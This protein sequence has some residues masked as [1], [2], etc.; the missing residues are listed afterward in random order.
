[1]REKKNE[2][3]HTL[4]CLQDEM[5]KQNSFTRKILLGMAT[6][7]GTVVGATILVAILVWVLSILAGMG[8]FAGFNEWLIGM[9]SR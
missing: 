8:I 2:L 7:F 4:K 5:E 3:V 6:G 9:L 1:M